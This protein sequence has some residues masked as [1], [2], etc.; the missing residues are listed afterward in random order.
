MLL[1]RVAILTLLL[2]T[3]W[4]G[5]AAGQAKKPAPPAKQAPAEPKLVP[6]MPAGAPAKPFRFPQAVTRTLPNGL[7]IFVVPATSS[8]PQ[9]AVTVRLVLTAAGAVHDPAGT[10]GVAEMTANLLTQGTEK[11]TAQQIAQAIDFV[12]GSLSASADNDATYVTASVVKKDLDLAMDL[13]SDVTLH[14]AFQPLELDRRREQLLSSLE[15]QYSDP[16]YLATVIFDRVMFGLNG[17]G[18][19]NEGTPD[20]ARALRRDD[21][22]RFRDSYYLPNQALL[23]F[24]GNIE[25]EAAFAAA[26]KYPG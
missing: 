8:A 5:A 1:R 18:L 26:E 22:A 23:A 21:L 17:Y 25:P 7:R 12:G 24:A 2:L 6:Q 9:P 19:P 11:R 4:C 15:V 16:N 20:T 3:A 10:R 13:L 14:A